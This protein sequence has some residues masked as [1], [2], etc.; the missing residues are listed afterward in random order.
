[1]SRVV[2]AKRTI[3]LVALLMAAIVLLSGPVA[4]V[5][6]PGSEPVAQ[7]KKKHKKKKKKK[8]NKPPAFNVVQCPKGSQ[9]FGTDLNDFLVGTD[10]NDLIRGGEGNDVYLAKGGDDALADDSKT[11]SDTY[12]PGDFGF[13]QVADQGGS[14]DLLDVGSLRL[15]DDLELVRGGSNFGSLVL[16]GPGSNDIFIVDYFGAGRIETI[17]FANGTIT[18]TQAESLAR[19]ATPEEQV[20]LEE[21][22]AELEESLP[23]EVRSSQDKGSP[24]KE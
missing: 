3:G 24:E 21:Q 13:E 20:A 12:F 22:R 1:M 2:V 19:E 7:A 17:R 14:A 16:D 11:S 18:G 15:G 9:C 4:E 6:D 23:E 10:A 8:K 5:L